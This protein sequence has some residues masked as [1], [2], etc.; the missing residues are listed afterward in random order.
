MRPGRGHRPGAAWKDPSSIGLRTCRIAAAQTPLQD[1][2]RRVIA[3]GQVGSCAKCR[4]SHPRHFVRR[5]NRRPAR[6]TGRT[7]HPGSPRR[8]R[9][10]AHR[11]QAHPVHHVTITSGHHIE[12]T[13]SEPTAD[14]HGD[15]AMPWARARRLAHRL[16]TPLGSQEVPLEHSAGRTLALPLACTA[17]RDNRPRPD[18]SKI[19]LARAMRNSSG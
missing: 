4:S 11:R 10:A 5:H 8:R 15:E 1:S 2:M 18:P 3:A 14:R 9:R 7:A 12:T 16:P 19:A 17:S 13:I 6:R